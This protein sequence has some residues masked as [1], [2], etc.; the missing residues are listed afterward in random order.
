MIDIRDLYGSI[1]G[2]YRV[3]AEN[4]LDCYFAQIIAA[5]DSLLMLL[6]D[7]LDL[8]LKEREVRLDLVEEKLTIRNKQYIIDELIKLGK[9]EDIGC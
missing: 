1:I 5:R 8:G 6:N 7:E 2:K 3:Y 4:E 9:D